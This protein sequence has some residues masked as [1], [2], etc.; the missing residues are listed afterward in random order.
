MYQDKFYKKNSRTATEQQK[1][2][3]QVI[4]TVSSEYLAEKM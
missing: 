4:P 2:N 1:Q 3:P